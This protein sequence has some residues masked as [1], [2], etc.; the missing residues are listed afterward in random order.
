[1]VYKAKDTKLDRTVALKFLPP[2]LTKSK[3]D[4]QRFTRE[5]KSA[6]A[7]NHPNICTI[8]SV[9]EYE[10]RQFI[11]MEYIDGDNLQNKLDS[12]EITIHIALEYAVQIADALSEAHK[13]DIVHRDIK[14][15]NIMV[16]SSGRVK[17]LDF[18]LAKLKG[19]TP[20]TQTGTTVGTVAYMSPEQIQAKEIDHRADLFSLGV[21]LFEMLTGERPFKGQYDAALT[22]AIANEDPPEL[23]SLNPKLPEQL[24]QMVNRLLQK[25]SDD[26]YQSAEELL[27][28]LEACLQQL[29]NSVQNSSKKTNQS[30]EPTSTKYSESQ[31][32]SDSESTSITIK[33]P[34]LRSP[35]TLAGL[36]TGFLILLL[37][38]YWLL[39][40]SNS[41][42]PPDN[43][44]AVLPLENMSPDPADTN[45]VD[46]VHV[47]LINRLAGIG[48]LTVIARS[49]VLDY[50]AGNHD[51]HQIAEELEVSSLMEGTVQRA[52]DQLRVSV[53]LVNAN[54]QSTIWS[55]SFEENVDDIFQMQS[56]IARQVAEELQASLTDEEQERLDERPT[57]NPV[58]YHLYLQ[59]REYLSRT[60]FNQENSLAAIKLFTRALE[61]EPDF[62]QSW[63]MLAVAHSNI[64]CFYEQNEKRLEMLEEAANMAQ[65][66]GPDLPESQLAAGLYQFWS[67]SDHEMT[68]S[69]FNE[70]LERFPNNPMLHRFTALTHRRLGNWK[71]MEDHLKNT[72]ELNPNN[73]NYYH[74][75]AYNKWY[76]RDYEEAKMY[77]DSSLE[78]TSN[79]HALVWALNSWVLLELENSFEGF[80]SWKKR[81]GPAK[82]SPFRW[83]EY[84]LLKSNF[85]RTLEIYTDIDEPIIWDLD[86]AYI[87]RDYL[88]ATVLYEKGD[89][90]SALDYFKELRNHLETL[91]DQ[92]PEKAGYRAALGKVYARLGEDEK[93]IEDGEKAVELLPIS[94]NAFIGTFIERDLAKIYTLTG[95]EEQAIDKLEYLLSI[96]SIIHRN[97]VRHHPNWDPLR[98]HPRFRELIAGKDKPSI[99]D[100]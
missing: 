29:P 6:A 40:F 89:T 85:E 62:S 66:L 82:N 20:I 13:K 47:E 70:A 71:R 2:H 15:G 87:H 53:Q 73:P 64:Y 61:E 60:Q 80:E 14:P 92:D 77:N 46:G 31:D 93:A 22:Y 91:R 79:A 90:S 83:G 99:E 96:P 97:W 4:K 28:N 7:L 76:V 81:G 12:R 24:S 94:Q 39:P 33:I 18:G 58:A 10:D 57:D 35:I 42:S 68:L 3:K 88:I 19:S 74:E 72:I 48:D 26:R 27:N 63:A 69:Y 8:Y 45:L 36:S 84:F 1:M 65:R 23:S 51:I 9:D 34:T 17:V 95:R 55:G 67:E 54:N 86:Y 52:D 21:V 50:P 78:L 100:L 43:S 75:L 30:E 44:I 41:V 16:D 49:S 5:A 98:D 11:S 25:D 37:V 59:G 32:S 56:R 38:G